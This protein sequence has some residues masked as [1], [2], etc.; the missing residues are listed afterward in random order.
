MK[1]IPIEVPISKIPIQAYSWFVGKEPLI[2]KAI[3]SKPEAQIRLTWLSEGSL[4]Y[5]L[6][7]FKTHYFGPQGDPAEKEL[8]KQFRLYL[9]R[10]SPI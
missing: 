4:H 2:A 1:A 8:Y 9:S 5:H 6:S 3:Q 7:Q 10:L